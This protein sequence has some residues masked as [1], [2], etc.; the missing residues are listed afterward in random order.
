MDNIF[1][2]DLFQDDHIF[3][4]VVNSFVSLFPHDRKI[5]KGESFYLLERR[6]RLSIVLYYSFSMG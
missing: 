5:D 6:D 3:S 1:D 4:A 2:R